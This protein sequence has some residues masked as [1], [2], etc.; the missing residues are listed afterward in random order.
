[1]ATDFYRFLYDVFPGIES[2]AIYSSSGVNEGDMMQWDT[3]SRVATNALLASGSI[4]LGISYE[5]NP[6]ASLGTTARPL[7]GSLCRIG[8]Q[9]IFQMKTTTSE[10]YSHLD[11]VYQGADTQTISKVGS[12]KIIGRVHLP[13]GSTVTGAAETLCSVRIL[14]NMTNLSCIPSS[15]A[16]AL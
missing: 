8:S 16:A 13:G 12:T 9:G 2:Y 10:V 11:P 14:G 3:G 7:T 6:L 1:M 15:A 4:F 5:T